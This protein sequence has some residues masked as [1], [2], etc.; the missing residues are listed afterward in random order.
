MAKKQT[1]IEETVTAK[2][3]RVAKPRAPRVKAATH[4]K[5]VSSE[6]PE[7]IAPVTAAPAIAAVELEN[8]HETIA[9]L[10]Y[11]FWEARGQQNGSA[12]DDWFRAE[13]LYRELS[14]SQHTA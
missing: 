12:V 1:T 8:S 5:T 9:R 13:N 4:S 14:T 11:G 7:A 2:P 10:A 3:R 6:V